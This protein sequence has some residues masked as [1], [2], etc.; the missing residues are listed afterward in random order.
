MVERAVNTYGHNPGEEL[1]AAKDPSPS[2]GPRDRSEQDRVASM[3][4]EGGTA[5]ARMDT[6]EQLESAPRGRV[7]KR[8]RIP[9]MWGAAA[10]SAA[11]SGVAL[12]RTVLARRIASLRASRSEEKRDAGGKQRA[13]SKQRGPGKQ[14][15]VAMSQSTNGTG[16]PPAKTRTRRAAPKKT[17]RSTATTTA[18]KG[19]RGKQGS[20]RR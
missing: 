19:S 17:R 8:R 4:D 1:M 2:F 20:A 9:W 16:A 11:V 13:A 14:P 5:A 6:L 15:A 12:A 18:R 7:K 3:A 10:A